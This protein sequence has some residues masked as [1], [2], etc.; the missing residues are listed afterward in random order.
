M[1]RMLYCMHIVYG[2]VRVVM[3]VGYVCIRIY[4]SMYLCDYVCACV[5]VICVGMRVYRCVCVG[6]LVCVYWCVYMRVCRCVYPSIR[7]DVHPS[8]NQTIGHPNHVD[9]YYRLCKNSLSHFIN[10]C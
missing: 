3:Y 7:I 9:N 10:G 2:M 5:L 4:A 6:V 1:I 8:D